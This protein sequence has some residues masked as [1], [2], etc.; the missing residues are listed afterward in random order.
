VE[1]SSRMVVPGWGQAHEACVLQTLD[2]L[3]RERVDGLLVA[4]ARGRLVVQWYLVHVVS[5][6]VLSCIVRVLGDGRG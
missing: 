2:D 5:C 6:C 3:G 4:V 1:I